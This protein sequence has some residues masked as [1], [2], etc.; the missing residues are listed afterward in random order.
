M[1]LQRRA[2]RKILKLSL[3]AACNFQVVAEIQKERGGK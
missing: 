2:D 3:E 1:N